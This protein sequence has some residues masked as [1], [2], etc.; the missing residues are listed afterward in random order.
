MMSAAFEDDAIT[1]TAP[2]VVKAGETAIVNVHLEVPDDSKGRYNGAIDLNIDDPSIREWEGQVQMDLEVW[3]QPTESYE[4]SFTAQ[5]D[6]PITI[7]LNSQKYSYDRWMGTSTNTQNNDVP[8]FENTLINPSGDEIEM[9]L[10]KTTY[11]GS[12]NLDMSDFPPWEMDGEGIYQEVDTSYSEIFAAPGAVG[13]WTLKVL[14]MNVD[15]FRYS[16]T[17][18]SSE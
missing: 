18:G 14:P 5:I 11:G 3:T 10:I 1:I 17:I 4:K 9:T 13:D 2:S 6:A 7:E 12:V 15:R 16:I 8:S